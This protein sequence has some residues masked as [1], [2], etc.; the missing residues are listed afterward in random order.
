MHRRKSKTPGI[1]PA[2]ASAHAA[3]AIASRVIETVAELVNMLSRGARLERGGGDRQ[4]S[5]HPLYIAAIHLSTRGSSAV[6]VGVKKK[7][8]NPSES[9]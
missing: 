3:K 5:R 9:R 6:I 8:K 1:N 2:Y 4:L 7:E